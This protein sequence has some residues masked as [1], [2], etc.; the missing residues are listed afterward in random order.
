MRQSL[1]VVGLGRGRVEPCVQRNSTPGSSV[2]PVSRGVPSSM[3]EFLSTYYSVNLD[4]P[5]PKKGTSYYVTRCV[6]P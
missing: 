5:E 1:K 3:L 6:K 4:V 2:S